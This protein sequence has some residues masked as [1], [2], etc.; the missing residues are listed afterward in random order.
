[1]NILLNICTDKLNRTNLNL[2]VEGKN[3]DIVSMWSSAC[4]GEMERNREFLKIIVL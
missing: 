3:D 4:A 2:F 1:M